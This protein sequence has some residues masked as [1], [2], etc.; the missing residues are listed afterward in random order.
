MTSIRYDKV[1]IAL[2]RDGKPRR[3]TAVIGERDAIDEARA[4]NL[5]PGLEGAQLEDAP[6]DDGVIIR[7]VAD[8]SPAAQRGL[9]P[10][11]LIMGV[12]RT[13]VANLEEFTRATR[14]AAP[15]MSGA[16]SIA[17][18]AFTAGLAAFAGLVYFRIDSVLLGLLRG[19]EDVGIYNVAHRIME[20]TLMISVKSMKLSPRSGLMP[21]TNMWWP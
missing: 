15:S 17:G 10:N 4:G 18:E 13:R 19:N 9:R 8:G 3:V 14:D 5:H 7:S 1:D 2:L 20:G 16:L 11:D 6:G 12:G 21:V